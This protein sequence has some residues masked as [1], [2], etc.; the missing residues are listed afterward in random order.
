MPALQPTTFDRDSWARWYAKSHLKTD[1]GIVAVNYLP[2]GS[3]D[4]EIRFIE[5]NE[6]IGERRDDA[7]EVIDYGVDS[8]T[9][10]EHRL[11]IL[12]VTPAQWSRM[13]QK[14]LAIPER[15]S[16]DNAEHYSSPDQID[17]GAEDSDE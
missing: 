16:L 10:T 7:L 12:D 8:G 15:W 1:P 5:V 17:T 4:R 2:T 6:L 11:F 9:E 13:C 14:S 3:G